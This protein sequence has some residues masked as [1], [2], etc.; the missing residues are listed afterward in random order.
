MRYSIIF[1]F[2]IAI[3]TFASECERGW[4][5]TKSAR[6]SET[7]ANLG[8]DYV[9]ARELANYHTRSRVAREGV[10]RDEHETSS[11]TTEDDVEVTDQE[12]I[13]LAIL[14]EAYDVSLGRAHYGRGGAYEGLARR[15]AT[16]AFATGDFSDSGA[17]SD[18]DGLNAN[19]LIAI[20]DWRDFMREKYAFV[21]VVRG[22]AF[23][24][25]DGE[26]TAM[27]RAFDIGVANADRERARD[28]ERVKMFPDC[29]SSWSAAKGGFVWC[30]VD[31]DG[32]ERYP[33][34]E[35]S[36]TVGGAF[37]SRCACFR[38][39]GLSDVRRAFYRCALTATKCRVSDAETETEAEAEAEAEKSA[40][41][42]MT[43]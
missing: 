27:K 3:V 19:E 32:V 37:T 12:T 31:A 8:D 4:M 29:A 40:G 1:A 28:L 11:M 43:A 5:G 25:D 23:Y 34:N 24:D 30:E 38:D 41:A 15:D 36:V 2:V 6:E 35:T 26:P 33:R 18:V 42:T 14:G 39:L 16:R 20:R 22:G 9:T 21:G 17:V 7:R 10:G 13:V